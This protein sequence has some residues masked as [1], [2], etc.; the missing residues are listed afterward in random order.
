MLS[1]VTSIQNKN[2]KINKNKN[3]CPGYEEAADMRVPLLQHNLF[4][5]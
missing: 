3:M 5:Q 2:G 1:I 4:D